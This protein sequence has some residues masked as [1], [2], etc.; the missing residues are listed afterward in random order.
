MRAN[1]I[2]RAMC[3]CAVVCVG[4]S[5]VFASGASA[6][7][8]SGPLTPG[9]FMN[10][11]AVFGGATASCPAAVALENTFPGARFVFTS[12][13]GVFYGP[14][15]NPLTAGFNLI[16]QA[17]LVVKDSGVVSAI[18]AGHAHLWAGTNVNPTGNLQNYDGETVSFQGALISFQATFGG[19]TSASGN[20]PGWFHSKLTCL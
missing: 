8:T 15:S 17:N 7:A 4:A 20:T 19:T 9:F 1:S 6:A 2:F 13:S 5:A 16:G 18:D 14:A 12:G 10:F 3:A 11:P